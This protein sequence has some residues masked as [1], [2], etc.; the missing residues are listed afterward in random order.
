[1]HDLCPREALE[2]PERLPGPAAGCQRG[3]RGM[4]QKLK[5][6]RCT[7]CQCVRRGQAENFLER[8]TF[9]PVLIAGYEIYQRRQQGER[10]WV[11]D[12]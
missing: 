8:M 3:S 10:P 6:K 12:V 7:A 5:Q 11:F 9:E 2:Y 1:M 4:Q